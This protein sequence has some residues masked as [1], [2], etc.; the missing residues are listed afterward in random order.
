MSDHTDAAS[1]LLRLSPIMGTQPLPT[2]PGTPEYHSQFI[3]SPA[4]SVESPPSSPP[5]SQPVPSLSSMQC[6]RQKR[7]LKPILSIPRPTLAMITPD[8][9][10]P[11]SPCAPIKKRGPF[12][13]PQPEASVVGDRLV[14][15]L[16][17]VTEGLPLYVNYMDHGVRKRVRLTVESAPVDN[18]DPVSPPPRDCFAPQYR[19]DAPDDM[20]QEMRRSGIMR[21]L[22][23]GAPTK[24]E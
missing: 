3:C 11:N 21:R 7:K 15:R 4:T 19:P 16:P 18:V 13:P 8:K 5:S 22:I 1:A 2:P 10:T 17:S 12:V 6:A 20:R 23:F 24:I 9:L 14:L